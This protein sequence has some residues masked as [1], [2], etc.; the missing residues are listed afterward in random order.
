MATWSK[1]VV[2]NGSG[3]IA[4][5]ASGIT[6]TTLGGLATLNSV[7][8][9]TIVDNSVGAAELN[10]SG[11]GSS[12][13]ALTSNANGSFSWTNISASNLTLSNF[14]GATIQL[15]SENFVDNDTTLMTSAAIKDKIESYSYTTNTGDITGVSF[16]A[17]NSS[18]VTD[19]SG[20]AAFTIT[21][22]TGI[23]TS[24]ASATITL[25]LNDQLV[26]IAGMT[27][28]ETTAL[29][30]ISETTFNSLHGKG[31]S[32]LNSLSGLTDA[33]DGLVVN[34]AS[35]S[36]AGDIKI[37][38]FSS[39]KN[40][41]DDLYWNFA[42]ASGLR[43]SGGDLTCDND[44]TIAGDLTVTG[45]TT[46]VNTE[47]ILLADNTIVIN[48]NH[49]GTPTQDGGITIERGSGTDQS[50]Y[51]DESADT[52][53]IGHSESSSTFTTTG[54]PAMIRTGSYVSSQGLV[55]GFGAVGSFQL[56]GTSLYV[57]TA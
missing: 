24:A 44:V 46:T 53:A 18:S 49:T 19:S 5:T 29:A 11:N 13:Q 41:M 8:A 2:E 17:D 38:T 43:V 57:R 56:N 52:W 14:S 21:G 36:T 23:A 20:Q 45:N 33:T 3:T 10:V 55:N 6:G 35:S 7:N 16:T 12:G 39:I 37:T 1:V 47:E 54:N 34:H 22:G 31:S 50:F 42:H 32:E 51:W 9:S 40:V 15:G 28:A 25:T 27:T 4:Q 30:T 26:D 48:S